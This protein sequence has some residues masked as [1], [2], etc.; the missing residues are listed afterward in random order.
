M[1]QFR[2]GQIMWA[3]VE[4]EQRQLVVDKVTSDGTVAQCYWTN[5]RIRQFVM[6]F[7]GARQ[8]MDGTG[9]ACSDPRRTT[10]VRELTDARCAHR[11][12]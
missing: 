8:K 5:G 9:S 3:L 6:V 4:G 11:L 10:L 1:H 2:K 12:R 7:A